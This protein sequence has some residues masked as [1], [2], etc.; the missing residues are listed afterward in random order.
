MITPKEQQIS[1][2]DI[3]LIKGRIK[4]GI[5][6]SKIQKETGWSVATICRIKQ[7]YYDNERQCKTV[8]IDPLE[9]KNLKLQAENDKLKKELST[10]EMRYRISLKEI[11]KL[12][13]E[14]EE[15]QKKTSE[16]DQP[17]RSFRVQKRES[18]APKL[19]ES[20]IWG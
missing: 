5:S 19:Q 4:E 7:G 13:R 3:E 14:N 15:L 17:K 16:N 1:K 20:H 10:M 9:E 12:E 2:F 18:S 6:Y 11:D 8:D